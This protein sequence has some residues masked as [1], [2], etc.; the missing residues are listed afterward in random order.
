VSTSRA[1]EGAPVFRVLLRMELHPGMEKEFE[2][3]WIKVGDA[4]TGH[5]GNVAQWLLRATEE[6]SVYYIVSD[7]LDEARFREFESSA[8]HVRHRELLHPYR[9]AG[10]MATMET[11]YRLRGAGA[12]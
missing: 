1:Q 2:E 5:P 7:W 11:V 4:V 8:A 6:D 10:S 9:T 3:A 12:G